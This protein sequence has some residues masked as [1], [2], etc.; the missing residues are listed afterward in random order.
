MR[1]QFSIAVF[2]CGESS[3]VAIA[4]GHHTPPHCA[5]VAARR[6]YQNAIVW[7]GGGDCVQYPIGFPIALECARNRDAES[8]HV[9]FQ[10]VHPLRV[11]IARHDQAAVLHQFR[12]V[13]GLSTRRCAGIQNFFVWL[14]IEKAGKAIAVLGSW[15]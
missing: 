4:I 11:T 5:G 12:E 3:P 1:E 13:T 15:M 8:C 10:D 2:A 6:I 9:F 14:G 7:C